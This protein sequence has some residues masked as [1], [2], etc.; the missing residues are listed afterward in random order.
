MVS[1]G[2][3]QCLLRKNYCFCF[4]VFHLTIIQIFVGNRKVETTFVCLVDGG[5]DYDVS[6]AG[7]ASDVEWR[8]DKQEIKGFYIDTTQRDTNTY[9]PD[10]P[11]G[12]SWPS[13]FV[14]VGVCIDINALRD[15]SRRRVVDGK[16]RERDG[17]Q[18][19]GK[20]TLSFHD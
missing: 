19:H 10:A 1:G 17:S 12:N 7:R 16:R 18:K 4:R 6:V 2:V 14:S 5:P 20:S 11:R 8:L 13:E 9:H 3:H 15:P